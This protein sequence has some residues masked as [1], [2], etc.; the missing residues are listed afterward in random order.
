MCT[1]FQGQER[2][3]RS[4]FPIS[5]YKEKLCERSVKSSKKSLL[6]VISL[7][8][9]NGKPYLKG[10]GFNQISHSYYSLSH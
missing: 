3:A 8:I 6:N 5:A 9:I 1:V 10:G 7:K 4:T 2:K